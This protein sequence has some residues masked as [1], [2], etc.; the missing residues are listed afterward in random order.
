MSDRQGHKFDRLGDNNYPTW[1]I[2]ML[3]QLKKRNLWEIVSGRVTRPLGS[4]NNAKVRAFVRREEEACAEIVLC[5]E[6][7]QLPHCRT[8]NPVE[9]WHNL[10]AVHRAHGLASRIALRRRFVFMI[11][12]STTSMQ[13]WISD[14]RALAQE[15]V[16]I[17]STVNDEDIILVLTQSLP[18]AYDAAVTALDATDPDLLTVAYV[19]ERLLGAESQIMS[20]QQAPPTPTPSTPDAGL[21]ARHLRTPIE[22]ITC[23]RCGQK[24]HYQRTCAL[25][26]PHPTAANNA[27]AVALGARARSPMLE[28]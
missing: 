24:G 20:R 13:A 14:V 4:E 17:G 9:M 10:A 23:F 25:P 16:A 3:A 18:A 2:Y 6:P 22:N 15:L 11:K 27:V 12:P 26:D 7:S 19:I 28:F 1:S 8:D 21:A 5:V